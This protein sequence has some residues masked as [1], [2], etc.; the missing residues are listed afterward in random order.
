MIR[1]GDWSVSPSL[2]SQLAS[3][4]KGFL[5]RVPVGSQFTV[6]PSA[7][8][9]SALELFLPQLLRSRYSE[10]ERES[11]D[12]IFMARAQKTST[13]AAQFAGT[14]ILISDQT[15]T[16][17]LVDLELSDIA[18]S[19]AAFRV[20]LGEPGGGP[21]GISGPQ[22]NSRDAERLLESLISRLDGIAWS[23]KLA[24]DDIDWPVVLGRS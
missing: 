3:E 6:E 14:C 7:D 20:F 24:S 9:C 17:F 18:D 10:W 16:P 2:E 8:L 19:V 13:A 15:V 21:L 4:L 1:A 11:L 23:Y 22:C 12:G 5:R